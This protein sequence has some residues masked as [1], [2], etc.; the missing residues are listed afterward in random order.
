MKKL[1]NNKGNTAII[2]CLLFTALLGFAAFVT[3]IGIVYAEKIKLYNALDAAALAAAL[4]LPDNIEKARKVAVEYLEKNSVDPGST[5]ITI[6]SDKKSIQIEG[7][8]NVKHL[9]APILKIY[10]SNIN[11]VVIAAIG[12]AKSVKGGIRPFAVE[13]FDYSYG[14]LVTLKAGAGDGYKG[15]YYAVALGGSGAKIFKENALYGYNSTISIGDLIYTETGNMADAANA[16]KNYINAERSSFDDFPKSSV[17]LWTVPLVDTLKVNG[18]GQILVA[19]FGEFYVEDVTTNSGKI[20]I[21]GR[22][23]RYVTNSDVDMTLND[24]GVY[25]AKLVK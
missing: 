18:T 10:S 19:G 4:E 23:I 16:I 25:G 15:N 2:L 24:T 1:N 6:G 3:D 5:V 11:A 22:F 14:S 17:R 20:E 13:T 12:P 21:T 7:V 9:F 8:K